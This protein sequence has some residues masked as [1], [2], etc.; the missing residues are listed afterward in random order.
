[1]QSENRTVVGIFS[2]I[3]EAKR[4]VDELHGQGVSE[5]R[6]VE[7]DLAVTFTGTAEREG[8]DE[9]HK[10]RGITGFF[11]R[12]FGM[13][14]D[15]P[16]W[17]LSSDSESYFQDAYNKKHHL[18]VIEDCT[19]VSLCRD[20][21]SR[22]G[23]VAEDQ[24][25]HHYHNERGS[26]R[27]QSMA[28][29]AS[30]LA[31]QSNLTANNGLTHRAEGWADTDESL[32]SGRRSSPDYAADGLGSVDVDRMP[33]AHHPSPETSASGHQVSVSD[34][35]SQSRLSGTADRIPFSD[36][37]PIADSSFGLGAN[38]NDSLMTGSFPSRDPDLGTGVTVP[39]A[40]RSFAGASPDDS[41]LLSADQGGTDDRS[42]NQ[43]Q[44]SGSSHESG[45]GVPS[46]SNSMP[47]AG[48]SLNTGITANGGPALPSDSDRRGVSGT[49]GHTASSDRALDG[50]S[51]DA[52]R[53]PLVGQRS[54]NEDPLRSAAT[55]LIG[56]ERISDRGVSNTDVSRLSSDRIMELD[57][58]DQHLIDDD[59]DRIENVRRGAAGQDKSLDN[60]HILPSR[61][62]PSSQDTPSAP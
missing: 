15:R 28:A 12:L 49:G 16:S 46:D 51:G 59:S 6:L 32:D 44:T 21:I 36:Q 20:I 26:Q 61:S 5:A 25:S 43:G 8:A 10:S 56:D 42:S 24:G 58:D 47:F 27:G 50:I 62:M 40:G 11:A 29:G 19:D 22:M 13:D 53:S 9:H 1:M 33:F 31:G 7:N 38:A 4:A 3:T 48:H 35:I 52:D 14:D 60:G 18:I 54:Y 39:T 57:D 41:L 45:V 34:R 2:D 30:G 17:K 55:S 37:A 23:G